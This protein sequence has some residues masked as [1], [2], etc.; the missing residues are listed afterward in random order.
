MPT[1]EAA[2]SADL[3]QRLKLV[4]VEI[5]SSPG[6]GALLTD[7]GGGG[8]VVTSQA[9][10]VSV[11]ITR[12]ANTTAYTAGDAVGGASAINAFAAFGAS[13]DHMLLTSA[14][15]RYDVSAVPSGMG[16]FRL[17]LYT[18][19]PAAIADNAAWD[20][21]AGDRSAYRGYIEFPAPAD[22]GA[23]LYSSIAQIN[24]HIQLAGTALYGVLQT[25]GGYTPAAVS[26]TLRLS[27]GGVRL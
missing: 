4:A 1:L 2:D 25:V 22:L 13:G 21:V 6:F 5:P 18:A 19:S 27:L 20:L 3:G 11:D 24:R 14:E 9:A 15:L 23:T 17:H 10:Y 8:G 16:A 7:G 12:P 26:E